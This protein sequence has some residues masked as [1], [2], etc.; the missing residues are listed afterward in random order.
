MLLFAA[1]AP[2]GFASEGLGLDVHITDRL[3]TARNAMRKVVKYTDANVR[4]SS[5]RG[6]FCCTD[7]EADITVT[8]QDLDFDGRIDVVRLCSATYEHS[9]F[10]PGGGPGVEEFKR[11]YEEIEYAELVEAFRAKY[12]GIKTAEGITLGSTY[13]EICDAYEQVPL[14]R[15]QV[16]MKRRV[17]YRRGNSNLIFVLIRDRVVQIVLVGNEDFDRV[18]GKL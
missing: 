2:T 6:A 9:A 16:G 7:D 1:C 15:E 3:E 5:V 17:V 10:A 18:Y 13:G 11:V 14:S 4:A 8:M 12:P